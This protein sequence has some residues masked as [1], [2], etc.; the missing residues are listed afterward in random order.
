MC[1]YNLTC[2]H[3]LFESRYVQLNMKSGTNNLS[4]FGYL[5][6]ILYPK[7]VMYSLT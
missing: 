7:L 4:G 1:P 6:L 5:Q 3:K 2:P